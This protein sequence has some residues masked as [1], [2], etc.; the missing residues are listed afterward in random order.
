MHVNSL[1]ALPTIERHQTWIWHSCKRVTRKFE[2]FRPRQGEGSEKRRSSGTLRT[3]WPNLVF[4]R[5]VEASSKGTRKRPKPSRVASENNKTNPRKTEKAARF[6]REIGGGGVTSSHGSRPLV[7]TGPQACACA[8]VWGWGA[9]VTWWWPPI[10][11]KNK[12]MRFGNR[13]MVLGTKRL[14]RKQRFWITN[15]GFG[16]MFHYVN[17]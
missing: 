8:R 3:F 15:S 2:P 5:Q 7:A 6:I 1:A 16:F 11:A 4:C 17:K 10:E 9:R 14:E 13:S 12:D